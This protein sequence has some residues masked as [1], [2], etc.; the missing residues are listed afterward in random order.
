MESSLLSVIYNVRGVHLDCSLN[1]GSLLLFSAW[2]PFLGAY[3][4]DLHLPVAVGC[5]SSVEH[6]QTASLRG[7]NVYAVHTQC[8]IR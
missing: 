1:D 6:A 5:E 3:L 8:R 4:A 7:S 2:P